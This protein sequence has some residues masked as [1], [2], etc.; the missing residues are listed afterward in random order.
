MSQKRNIGMFFTIVVV[1]AI[2]MFLPI[3]ELS[4]SGRR[5]LGVFV[6]AALCWITEVIPIAATGGI[7]VGLLALLLP[8]VLNGVNVR[9]FYAAF[10]APVIVLFA[11]GYFLAAA[12]QKYCMD[13]I[14]TAWILRRTG[15]KP[16]MVLGGIMLATAFLSMWMSNTATTALMIAVALPVVRKIKDD[17]FSVAFLLG[18]PFAANVGG[19]A[20]PIGTP[21]NAIAIEFLAGVGKNISFGQWF[22]WGFPITLVM[23]IVI[24]YL[25]GILF[26]PKI[27]EI[28]LETRDIKFTTNHKIVA[29]TFVIT[30][31]LWFTEKL[32]GVSTSLVAMLPPAVFL[33]TGVLTRE[34]IKTSVGWDI[35]ILVAGGIALGTAMKVSG[36]SEWILTTFHMKA[37]SPTMVILLFGILSLALSAFMSHTAATNLLIPLAISVGTSVSQVVV[38]TALVS[39]CAMIF[40]VSTPPNAIAYGS[41]MIKSSD[42][43][44]AGVV[45]ALIGFILDYAVVQLLVR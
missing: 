25:L 19:I 36:L 23:T 4:P 33:I 8:P 39:S 35:L 28:E 21:P 22:M 16:K 2:T 10:S 43:S 17:P 29:I 14:F 6:F 18:I 3:P 11:G 9:T 1:S 5:T 24:W 37:L 45:I 30:A 31:I 32:H 7:A 34:D 15:T 13:E 40:P 41:G 27:K 44:K 12:M 38:M 42:M 20:T 26:P